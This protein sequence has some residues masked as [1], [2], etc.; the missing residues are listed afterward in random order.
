[1]TAPRYKEVEALLTSLA[2]KNYRRMRA[3]GC[4]VEF[5]DL[6]QEAAIVY[7]RAAKRFDAKRGVK[8]TTYLWRA[9]SNHFRRMMDYDTSAATDSLNENVGEGHDTRLDFVTSAEKS[10]EDQIDAQREMEE[11][12]KR[13]SPLARRVAILMIE[14]TS[15]LLA[16]HARANAFA[17]M[18]MENNCKWQTPRIDPNFIMRALGYNKQQRTSVTDEFAA[19]IRSVHFES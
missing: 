18:C 4:S 10:V 8:F 17:Q 12:L 9:V 14:P 19:L 5:D 13:L 15:S 1:M 7:H 6:K 11:N 16:E 3:R 2:F